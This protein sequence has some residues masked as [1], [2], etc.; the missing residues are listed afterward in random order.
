M[1][2]ETVLNLLINQ[3]HEIWQDEDHVASLLFLNIIEIYDQMI[4]SRLIHVLWVK[5]I[6]KQLA[7]QVRVFMMNR[8]ST[9]V[10]SDTETEEKS[11]SAEVLQRSFLSLILY[12]FYM[13]KLLKACNNISDQLSA[14]IFIN[15]I[16]LLIYKQITEKNYQILK[17]I[18]N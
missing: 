5:R 8:T 16:I 13:M 14:S 10:L 9:L 18:Y 4:C 12:L 6:F 11:I 1:I 2:T 17:N 15:D 3:V 7:E